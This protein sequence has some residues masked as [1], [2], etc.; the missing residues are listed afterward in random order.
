VLYQ[1]ADDLRL[2]AGVEEFPQALE[3]CEYHPQIGFAHQFAFETP[4]FP[5][6]LLRPAL[7]PIDALV[8]ICHL[9]CHYLLAT[10]PI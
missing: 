3:L 8:E 9:L 10:T 7:D 4:D 2:L 6:Y 1:G 5:K